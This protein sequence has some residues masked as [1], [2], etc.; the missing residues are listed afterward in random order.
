MATEIRLFISH[1]SADVE[2]A[3]RLVDM[4]RAALN[5]PSATIRC[6]SVDGYRLPGGADTNEQLR[7]EVHDAD[8]FVGIV[9]AGSLR[10]PY[11][12]FELGARWGASKHLMPVL[13]SGTDPS[14]LGSPLGGLNA[15]RTDSREQLHQI[16][17][18]L[19]KVL[20]VT[21]ESPAAYGKHIAAILALPA[22]PV[23]MDAVAG[24]RR[25]DGAK[26]MRKRPMSPEE[27]DIVADIPTEARELLLAASEDRDGLVHVGI[28]GGALSLRTNGR[29][30][31]ENAN[32]RSQAKWR[33]AVATLRE[34]GLLRIG[35][36]LSS[37]YVSDQ[38][39]VAA[40]LLSSMDE[41]Y[42]PNLG[43]N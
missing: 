28:S 24:Q 33:R 34:L 37:L 5:L 39:F 14:I 7:R 36:D 20:N 30:L 1:S 13:S 22:K 32:A 10:S 9:S 17:N 6:T 26:R 8:A 41:S 12:L 16:V 21:P 35:E 27:R 29:E 11:V 31:V 15:L 42:D 38:G 40:D 23:A 2:L 3:A 19:G 18:D 43:S 4:L 25:R